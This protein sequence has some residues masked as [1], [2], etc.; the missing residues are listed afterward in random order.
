MVDKESEQLVEGNENM[1]VDTFMDDIIN[2]QE[3]P[4]TRIE[5]RSDKKSMEVMKSADMLIIHDDEEEEG[6][7]G[8][9]F[10]L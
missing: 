4:D 6:S 2:D 8:D 10:E 9:E 3:D 5:P 7:A 1:N